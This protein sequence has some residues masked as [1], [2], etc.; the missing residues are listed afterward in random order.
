MV[1]FWLF[2]AENGMNMTIKFDGAE[3]LDV[4]AINLVKSGLNFKLI[5]PSLKTNSKS[6]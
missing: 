1:F 4:G 3:V 5:L 6:P 2:S